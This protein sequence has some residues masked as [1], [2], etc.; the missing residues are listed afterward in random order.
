[1]IARFPESRYGDLEIPGRGEGSNLVIAMNRAFRD[2]ARD[3][4]LRHK[5]PNW[6]YISVGT[7]GMGAIRFWGPLPRPEDVEGRK[8]K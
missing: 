6:I 4:R 7:G 3:P 5:S 1:M 8:S 2:I